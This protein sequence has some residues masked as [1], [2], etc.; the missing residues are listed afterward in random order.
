[1]PFGVVGQMAPG[2]RRIVR[3]GDR[4]TGRGIFGAN[5]GR[6]IVTNGDFTAYLCDSAA[7]RPFLKLL[8]ADLLLFITPIGKKET[9]Q[10]MYM[11]KHENM[12]FIFLLS[13][14]IVRQPAHRLVF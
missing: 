12:C 7:T 3:F 4:S 6:A 8:W 5:L 13:L 1:M 14:K 11:Q 9:Q 2:M 10:K